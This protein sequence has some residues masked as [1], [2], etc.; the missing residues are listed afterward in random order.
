MK[1]YRLFSGPDNKTHIEE[2]PLSAL[3]TIDSSQ[4][5][6]AV[7]FR[8]YPA[9][10]FLDWHPAPRRQWVVLMKGEV[11]FGL[12]DGSTHKLSPGDAFLAED[13]TG[14]GHT[15]RVGPEPLFWIVVPLAG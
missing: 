2:L 10:Y 8:G 1:F 3:P 6:V 5:A 13:L 7:F 14:K 15:A 12:E 4:S 11:E 9:G